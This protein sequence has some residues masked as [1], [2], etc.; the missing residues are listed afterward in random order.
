MFL[1]S[2]QNKILVNGTLS[3]IKSILD[4]NNFHL[5]T[6]GT[7]AAPKSPIFT[8]RKEKKVIYVKTMKLKNILDE[9]EIPIKA[10]IVSYCDEEF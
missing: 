1:S 2:Q 4:S 3:G 5:T 8:V 6:H 10:K 9:V 7:E